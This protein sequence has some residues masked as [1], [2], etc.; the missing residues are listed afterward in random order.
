VLSLPTEFGVGQARVG[1]EI[2]D[3]TITAR[4]NLV[5]KA[6]ANG[7][8]EGLDHVKN[9]RTLA[10]P[11][12]PGLD[13]RLLLTKIV[14]SDQVSLGKIQNMDVVTDGCTILGFVV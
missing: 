13:T 11:K 10:G 2:Q 14:E 4:S 7:M 12:I 1:G 6:T 9:S 8:T 3:I 5:G